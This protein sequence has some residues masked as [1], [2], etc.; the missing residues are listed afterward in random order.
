MSSIQLSKVDSQTRKMLEPIETPT[1]PIGRK[2][3][4]AALK[5]LTVL[6]AVLAAFFAF[7]SANLA[8]IGLPVVWGGLV[9][10]GFF[11]VASVAA[12]EAYTKLES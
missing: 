6:F 10:T 5:I 7:V 1:S 4:V 11:T 2:V 3:A 12:K 8:I 9:P